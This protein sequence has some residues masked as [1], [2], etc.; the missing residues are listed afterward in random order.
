MA[1]LLNHTFKHSNE[2]GE[3]IEFLSSVTVDSDGLFHVGY[4]AE[5]A[6]VFSAYFESDAYRNSEAYQDGRVSL[7]AGRRPCVTATKLDIATRFVKQALKARLTCTVETSQH[8]LYGLEGHVAVWQA[9][10]G[11]LYSNGYQREGRWID[12]GVR[13][14]GDK[15]ES[16]GRSIGI[17]AGV[18]TKTVYTRPTGTSTVWS[19]VHFCGID[20]EEDSWPARLNTLGAG[21][22]N[23]D[24]DLPDHVKV[25]D[26][27][28]E[29]CR[30]FY[31]L[32]MGIAALSK[33]IHD[34]ISSPELVTKA[35]ATHKLGLLALPD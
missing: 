14:P 4:P 35:I 7:G 9:P 33:R 12:L 19:I 24:G 16:C 25:L 26:P 21:P 30:F 8:L 18:Y 29:N 3:T 31:E 11:T 13:N 32:I 2:L 17:A 27:T 10:D 15:P 5:H 22:L 20:D 6:E 28:E 1:K 34:F 23:G